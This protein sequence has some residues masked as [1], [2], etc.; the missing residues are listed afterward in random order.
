MSTEFRSMSMTRRVEVYGSLLNPEEW[1]NLR[2]IGPVRELGKQKRTGWKLSFDKRGEK[3]GEAVLNLVQTSREED[4]FYTTV[5]EVSNKVYMEILK[6][7]MGPRLAARWMRGDPLPDSSYRPLELDGKYGKTWLFII[8]E[9]GRRT[10]L[11]TEEASYVRSVRQGIE[12]RYVGE[13]KEA[14][15]RA[16]KRAIAESLAGS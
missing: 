14:D 3:R 10:T 6:R 16:L 1:R 9:E 7:E 4:V 2:E 8:P 5:Y 15:L 13:K 11:T 12:Q